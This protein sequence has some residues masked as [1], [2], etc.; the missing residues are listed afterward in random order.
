MSAHPV[1]TPRVRRKY[2]PAVGPKLRKLLYVVF[3]LSALLAATAIYLAA[4]TAMEVATGK[5]YQNWFYQLVFLAHLGLGLLFVV[6]LIAF[7][8]IHLKKTRQR[9]NRRAMKAGMALFIGS[10]VVLITGLLLVRLVGVFDL[11]HPFARST[12]YWLHVASPI[13]C[14]W[15]YWLH[16][17]AGPKIHWK[18]GIIG[19]SVVMA[20]VGV[21][22]AVHSQD[23]RQWNSVGP[24]S[25]QQYFEPSLARTS[26][27][28]FIP[29]T[30]LDNDE[31]CQSCHQDVH[32][33]WEHSVHH[34]SSFNNPVY[35]ASVRET[36][37]VA[38]KRDGSVKASRW[39]AGC[40]DP[41]PFFSGA[42]DDPNFDDVHHP[43]AHSGIT[44]TTCHAITHVNSTRGNADF[45]IEEPMHYPF[46]FS[47]NPFLKWVNGQLIKAKPELHKKTFLKPLHQTAEFCSTCH[48]VHLPK[49]LTHYK[50][51]LR[52]QNHYDSYLLSGVS[53]HGA[54]SFYYP[55]KAA[56]NCN[57]CHMPLQPSSDFG[58]KPIG[59]SGE[60]S[61]HDHLFPAAN[62]GIA[63]TREWSDIVREQSDYLKNEIVRVDL[64]GLREDG[65]ID[66][67]LLAPLRPNVPTVE[68]GEQYLL[69]AVIRTMKLGHHLTQGTIDS[70]EL[71]LELTVRSGD[72][73]IGRSGH[74]DT[75]QKVDPWSHFVSA[76]VIDRNGNR[77][78]RRNPQDIFVKL[79][80]H[81]IPP[82]AGQTVHYDLDVPKDLTEPITIELR[83]NYRKFDNVLMKFAADSSKTDDK[84]FRG[85]H[86]FGNGRNPL[87]IVVL[88]EDS[89][90]LPI[91][92]QTHKIPKQSTQ[93]PE[94]QRW[95]DYGIGLLLKGKAELRQAADAFTEV[96][97]LGRY[98]GALNL[99]RV[100]ELEGRINEAT[101]AL[102]RAAAH[103]KPSAP[104]WTVNWL[105][106]MLNREQGRL[107]E[108]AENFRAVLSPPTAEMKSRGFDFRNDYIVSNLLGQTL[109]DLARQQRGAERKTQRNKFLT[110]AVEQ[111]QQTLQLDIENVDAHYNLALLYRELG[112]IDKADRHRQLHA[113]YKPDDNARDTAVRLAR[114]KYP[115]ANHAAE[116]VVIYPTDRP[117]IAE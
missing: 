30:A 29:A 77:I 13:V 8:L 65:E 78:S 106:G 37:E 116:A 102:N 43:T 85:K 46:A 58:A 10:I 28:N 55:P 6:P 70:N 49:S 60:L 17:L 51:F 68:P 80:D 111:Y 53:G 97:K 84:P 9:K 18:V 103:K 76:F 112:E 114:Q 33:R 15:L 31:Y 12:V 44:C 62:T 41:V 113:R 66:G 48:K 3:G 115:A 109:F 16:R 19:G 26:T 93:I 92:G 90:T 23:P 35:L 50:D 59:E 7:G 81:Q 34:L 96:E 63:W 39:C 108:A 79:Y 25:G 24:E 11:R 2:E 110:A 14:I 21:M 75:R 64:F 22:V 91:A 83:L 98:D 56:D 87:P 38:L 20:G 73:V 1:A 61:V 4:I 74:L 5:V 67:R 52:G 117:A 32:A 104:P 86:E 105:S 101:D 47:D 100:L 40:H 71:W 99:T 54:R 82:G 45:T 95:N 94:W 88:A 69:E 72:R 89:L 107:T 36:R 42:F 57:V 27:G